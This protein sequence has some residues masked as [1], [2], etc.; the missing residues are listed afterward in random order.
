[1]SA[2]CS[3]RPSWRVSSPVEKALLWN[4]YNGCSVSSGAWTCFSID[5]FVLSLHCK[6]QFIVL[7]KYILAIS[8]EDADSATFLFRTNLKKCAL[9]CLEEKMLQ[10]LISF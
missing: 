1:M 6:V 3:A 4:D 7:Q 5:D 9:A 10:S 2:G 8:K